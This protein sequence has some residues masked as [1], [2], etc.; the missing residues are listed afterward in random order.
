M[1]FFNVLEENSS[2]ALRQ[3]DKFKTTKNENSKMSNHD[4]C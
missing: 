4:L 1:I 2:Q 3:A